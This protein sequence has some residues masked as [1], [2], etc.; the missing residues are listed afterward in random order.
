MQNPVSSHGVSLRVLFSTCVFLPAFLACSAEPLASRIDTSV[1]EDRSSWSVQRWSDPGM[2]P[3][4]VVPREGAAVIIPSGREILLD[5]STPALASLRIDG[6]LRF[7]DRD[8]ELISGAVTVYGRLEI[9]SEARPFTHH[10]TI[11]LVGRQTPASAE[12]M[13]TKLIGVMSNAAL[14]LHGAPRTGWLRLGANAPAGATQ[15]VLERV[16]DDWR[17]GDRVVI[18]STDRD[19]THAEVVQIASSAGSAV[20]LASPLR[21]AH[22]GTLQQI[23]GRGVDERAEV[24]LLTRNIV[25]RGDSATSAGG[26]GGHVM[27][28][29]GGVAH[30]DGAELTYMGQLGLLARYPMH[31]HMAGDVSGQYVRNSSIWHSF[32]RCVTVH[33]SHAATVE[34]NVCYDHVGHGFFLEDGIETRNTI[35]GNLGLGTQASAD[36]RPLMTDRRPATFWI[37]NPDNTVRDNVAAGSANVGFWYA[38]PEHPTGFSATDAVSPNKLPVREFRGNVAHS[39]RV[40]LYVDERPVSNTN[41]ESSGYYPIGPAGDVTGDFQDFRAYKNIHGIW[42]RGRVRLIRPTLT[43]NLAGATIAESPGELIDPFVVGETQNTELAVNGQVLR[44]FEF[45]DGPNTLRGGTF[46]NFASSAAR[47]AG[48]LSFNPFNGAPLSGGHVAEGVRFIDANPVYVHAP[49]Q[50]GDK[51]AIF[52]DR[53]GSVTGIPAATIVTANPMLLLPKC[54]K[55]DAWNAYVCAGARYTSALVYSPVATDRF[56]PVTVRRDDGVEEQ[57]QGTS[58]RHIWPTMPVNREYTI[59][60]S[61]PLSLA[62]VAFFQLLPDEWVILS[63]PWEKP[64]AYVHIEGPSVVAPNLSALRSA[65]TTSSYYDV[66]AKRLY[67]KMFGAENGAVHANIS[68]NP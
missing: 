5:V 47:P 40:G 45:Y 49:I 7:D 11:T 54:S 58:S 51:A 43:D 63:L 4:G 23:A 46:V 15:V 37:T 35:V 20:T 27:V 14:E 2:W 48:A 42:A 67:V 64:A 18:A 6:T 8:L 1:A 3:H 38:M 53:D 36:D 68:P 50:D 28:M 39:T 52:T 26:F 19:P 31:W 16:P 29:G 33:G 44:G 60:T 13:G 32:N 66:T 55:R 62:T 21:Y 22:W 59:T 65:A 61:G 34:N 12:G 10:A 41:T 30:V 17:A 57:L 9:G 25:V 56:T 24:G